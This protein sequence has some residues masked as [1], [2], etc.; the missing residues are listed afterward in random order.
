MASYVIGSDGEKTFVVQANK[1]GVQLGDGSIREVVG[2]KDFQ[3]VKYEDL[4]DKPKLLEVGTK[5]NEAKPGNWK[6]KWSDVAGADAAVEK[7]IKDKLKDLPI[8]RIDATHEQL[9]EYVN[10]LVTTLRS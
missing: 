10:T 3:D 9:I 7:Y 1:I 6:P 8:P 4:K 5:A 2:P